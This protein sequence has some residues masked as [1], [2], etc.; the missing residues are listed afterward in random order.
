VTEQLLSNAPRLDEDHIAFYDDV[1]IRLTKTIETKALAQLSTSLA[2]FESAPKQTVRNLAYHSEVAVSGPVLAQSPILSDR[3]L[4]SIATIRGQDHLLAISKRA[5]I[6]EIVTD[7]LLER[8]NTAVTHTL[9]EN[10]GARFSET[11][12]A[13]LAKKAEID[14]ALTEELGQ[15]YYIPISVLKQL[16]SRATHTVRCRLLASAAPEGRQHIQ[17]IISA[18]AGELGRN[19]STS[20]TPASPEHIVRTLNQS[21]KLSEAVVTR[22]ALIGQTDEVKHALALMCSVNIDT[23]D[24]LT[25][26]RNHEGVVLACK[27]AHLSWDATELILNSKSFDCQDSEIDLRRAEETYREI[28]QSAALRT[29][30]F[31]QAKSALQNVV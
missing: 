16:V 31:M 3:D 25:N 19:I 23:I 4:V 17:P 5:T 8:G 10:N 9:V 11:G 14:P 24:L 6:N 21:G 22:F 29:L 28:S 27:A 12:F 1:L 15:R 7:T 18:V 20:K 30:R 26:N 2:A 13:T